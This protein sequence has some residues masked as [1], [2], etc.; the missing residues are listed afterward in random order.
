[1]PAQ[2]LCP[3]IAPSPHGLSST[4]HAITLCP[5]SCTTEHRPPSNECILPPAPAPAAATAAVAERGAPGAPQLRAQR[6]VHALALLQPLCPQHPQ[7]D[8][9]R[10][11]HLQPWTRCVP[12]GHA[13]QRRCVCAHQVV[14]SIYSLRPGAHPKAMPSSAAACLAQQCKLHA[15]K[16]LHSRPEG[17]ALVHVIRTCEPCG[18][19]CPESH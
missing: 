7:Q 16:K 4:K 13:Q 14:C 8:V 6:G 10:A 19:G 9:P 2:H 5:C 11:A 3:S 1:M 12:P 15:G 17:E 18:R